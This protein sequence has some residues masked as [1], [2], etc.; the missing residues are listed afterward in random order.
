MTR[1]C[2]RNDSGAAVCGRDSYD[3]AISWD[4]VTCGDCFDTEIRTA[5]RLC[6]IFLMDENLDMALHHGAHAR[7][8][9]DLWLGLG[10]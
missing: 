6:R 10:S 4:S 9:A 5:D 3:L 2:K 7:R 8:L 1:I